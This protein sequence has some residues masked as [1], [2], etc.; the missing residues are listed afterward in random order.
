MQA[1]E[2]FIIRN[3]LKLVFGFEMWNFDS[4]NWKWLGVR[5]IEGGDRVKVRVRRSGHQA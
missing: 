2:F 3:N 4:E 5:G 1:V